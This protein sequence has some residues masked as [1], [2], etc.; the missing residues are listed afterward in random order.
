MQF[1][2]FYLNYSLFFLFIFKCAMPRQYRLNLDGYN[3]VEADDPHRLLRLFL[4]AQHVLAIPRVIGL[5]VDPTD[6]LTD[7]VFKQIFRVSKRAA[8]GLLRTLGLDIRDRRGSPLL[9]IQKLCIFLSH[10]ANNSF[11]KITGICGHL[12][13]SVL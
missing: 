2:S 5:R 1:N 4:I 9:P 13:N 3:D 6:N 10:C 12:D 8:H 11:Q 7:T